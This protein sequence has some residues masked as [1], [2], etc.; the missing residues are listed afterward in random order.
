M[1]ELQSVIKKLYREK[2]DEVFNEV[3]KYRNEFKVDTKPNPNLFW[4]KF[5]NLYFIYPDAMSGTKG[6][7]LE[8]LVPQIPRIKELGCNSLHILPFLES[9][10]V[11]KGFDV[12]DYLA[13]R[14]GLGSMKDIEKIV[15]T[16]KKNGVRLFMDLVF[17][18]V[19]DQHI[20]YQKAIKR[21]EKYRN[22][23]I[24]Q[25]TKPD[26]I[27]K[28][29]RDSAVWAT[30]KINGNERDINI[31]FPEHTGEIPH[32]REGKDGYWYYHTYYPEQLD[33]NWRNPDVFLEYAKIIMYWASRGFNFRLDAIPFVGKSAYK[34]VDD[35]TD[36]TRT[37]LASFSMLA[38]SINQETVF[39]ME[40]Y[41]KEDTVMDYF[42]TTNLKQAQ[43]GYNFH[44]CTYL[45]VALVKKNASYIWEK[46]DDL[47]EIPT[48]AEWINFLRNHDELSL[49]YLPESLLIDVKKK[50][51]KYGEPFR[52]GY[53]ISGR[54]YSLLANDERK[55]V[56]AYL[57]LASMP[58][59][60]LIPYGDEVGKTNIPINKLSDQEKKDTRNI[61]RGKLTKKELDSPKGKRIQARFHEILTARNALRQYENIWPEKIEA[62]N[63]VF[64]CAYVSGSSHLVMMINI[65]DKK[66]KVKFTTKDF[67]PV[68]KLFQVEIGDKEVTL[69]PHSGLWLQK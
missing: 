24:Y 30:Y 6:T 33:V 3:K 38:E 43:L 54:T 20:W 64:A 17:N 25:K 13:V 14:K 65:S 4:Y 44:L 39:I 35:T 9:P 31:A 62:P 53:G 66:V 2:G 52:E 61:N 32:W 22:Y 19:S 36:F 16:A 34:E 63:G 15:E 5:L 55:F 58:G 56:N 48:H 23:F 41:E 46:L 37:L 57:L 28:F 67:W 10:M 27:K 49:A 40:T 18:H 60:M 47:N 45:W 68:I 42:G 26:F 50:L 69:S 12:S 51:L 11:D 21:D 8:R 7:P 59:G 29:H 1:D